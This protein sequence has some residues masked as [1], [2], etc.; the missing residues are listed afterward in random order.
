MVDKKRND[1]QNLDE[2]RVNPNIAP[3]ES[4]DK[5]QVEDEEKKEATNTNNNDDELFDNNKKKKDAAKPSSWQDAISSMNSK[6]E[7]ERLNKIDEYI[8]GNATG[9]IDDMVD[10][11]KKITAK[12]P[13][14]QT[15]DT[16][17]QEKAVNA[18]N[19]AAKSIEAPDLSTLTSIG[20]RNI[21]EEPDE[22]ATHTSGPA[23]GK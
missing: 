20:G 19:N 18:A 1:K 21:F 14:L 9:M 10:L 2:P 15:M 7:E 6:L 16:A 23:L 8:K 3:M 4:M 17:G 13:E 11:Y 22:Q 12:P 5:P